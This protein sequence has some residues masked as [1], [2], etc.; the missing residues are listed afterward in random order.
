MLQADADMAATSTGYQH[1]SLDAD[2]VPVIAGTG[3]KVAPLIEQFKAR[4][5]SAEELRAHY[6]DLTPAQLHSLLAYYYDRAGELEE[7]LQ[8][9][10]A[11]VEAARHNTPA[12]AIVERLRAAR[13]AGAV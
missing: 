3:Y 8:R 11:A 7:D 10:A 6:P 9:R 12:P 1:I 5:W 13:R 2:G 4:N